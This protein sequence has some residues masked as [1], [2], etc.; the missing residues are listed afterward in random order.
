MKT[1]ALENRSFS[2]M[3]GFKRVNLHNLNG[4]NYC[5]HYARIA[6]KIPSNDWRF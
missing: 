1:R 3:H 4:I 6:I 2:R 5:L